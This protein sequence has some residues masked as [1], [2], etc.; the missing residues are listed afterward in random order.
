MIG[1]WCSYFLL[2]MIVID[3]KFRFDISEL[4]TWLT[5]KKYLIPYFLSQASHAIAF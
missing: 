4:T 1:G 3:K 5:S 2:E